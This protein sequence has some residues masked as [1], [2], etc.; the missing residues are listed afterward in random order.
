VKY[1]NHKV[2]YAWAVE[3]DFDPSRAREHHVRAHLA[4]ALGQ[5][6]RVPEVD[7]AAWFGLESARAA[8]LPA[9]RRFLD[10]LEASR[11]RREVPRTRRSGRLG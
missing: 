1:K 10:D 11:R 5:G 8:I 2:V 3:G 7:R 9:Q 4:A 6:H